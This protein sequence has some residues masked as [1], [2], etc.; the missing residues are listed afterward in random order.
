MTSAGVRKPKDTTWA[1]I[2][3]F[4]H[5]SQVLLGELRQVGTFRAEQSKQAISVFNG[6]LGLAK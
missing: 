1:I 2:E 3:F 6:L 4:G 5:F